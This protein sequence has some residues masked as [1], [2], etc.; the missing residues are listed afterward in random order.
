[1][2]TVKGVIGIEKKK[3]VFISN[4][5]SPYQVK[6]C[7]ALR[8]Y[9]DAEFWFYV[10]REPNRPKWWEIP[11][12][13]KC[14]VLKYSGQIFSNYFSLSI[15]SELNKFKPDIILLGGFMQWHWLVLRWA[16]IFGGKVVFMSE[17]LRD[18]TSDRDAS[19]RLM[20]R[21]NSQRKIRLI[22]TIFKG[23]DL[24]LGMGETATRQ[25]KEEFYFPIEKVDSIEYPTDIDDYFEHPLREKKKGDNFVILF[26]NR[27]INRY[28]PLYALKILK[29]LNEK[30]PNISMKMN[31]RGPLKEECQEYIRENKLENVKFIREIQSWEDLGNIYKNSDIVILPAT[32]SNG[33]LTLVDSGASG[34]GVVMSDKV[35]NM[36]KSFKDKE[37]C[38]ICKVDIDEFVQAIG[39]YIENP[40]LLILHGKRSRELLKSE[41]NHVVARDYYELFK[42]HSF[43]D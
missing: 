25:F 4:M 28:Q 16:K 38:F 40:E 41:R 37:N 36:E 32:Y 1:M 12:G 33:N 29:K 9:F 6:F 27:L 17:L 21:E 18:G 42:K 34:M 15:F 24:Y 5:A 8:E 43:I 11:L 23:A 2:R 22:S 7:Y 13:D 3:L 30:Y 10:R 35:D 31:R 20:T 14:K 39:K 19:D 26:A